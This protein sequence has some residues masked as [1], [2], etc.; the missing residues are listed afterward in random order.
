MRRHSFE[1]LVEMARESAR[2][3]G[4]IPSS[5]RYC[6]E[7]RVRAE[8]LARFGGWHAVALA[9]FGEGYAE[10]RQA[11]KRS[12]TK[13][14]RDA[15]IFARDERAVRAFL[16]HDV[17]VFSCAQND[18][19]PVAGF[20][21]ALKSY[22]RAKDG[23][24]GVIPIRHKN[25]TQRSDPSGEADGLTWHP[26]LV[27]HMI[28]NE[29]RLAPDLVVLGQVRIQA[30][31]PNPLA[32]KGPRT[33]ASSAIFGHPKLMMK[34]IPTSQHE[35][36]KLLY[37]TG[38]I[39]KKNYSG[40]D[41]GDMADF[42]HVSGAIVVERDGDRWWMRSLV[43]DGEAFYDLD[44]R[45][46]AQGFGGYRRVSGLITGDTHVR[47][48]DPVVAQLTYGPGGI[49]EV[50]RPRALVWHDSFDGDTINHHDRNNTILRAIKAAA[51]K[52]RL[53]DELDEWVDFIASASQACPKDCEQIIVRSNHDERLIRWLE[54]SDANVSPENLQI[55][56][57]LKA[58]V[59]KTGRVT[60]RGVEYEDPLKLYAAKRGLKARFLARDEKYLIENVSVTNHGDVGS[61]GAR[62]SAK[63][64]AQIGVRTMTAHDHEGHIVEGN[65]GV[66]TNSYLS[67][68]YNRRGPSSWTHTDGIVHENGRRQLIHIRDGDWRKPG[69]KRTPRRKR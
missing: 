51:G 68:G 9:A 6:Q 26:D 64:F 61:N 14:G 56:Y 67:L 28:E 30:T 58:E 4:G 41:R 42:H 63:G 17:F 44:E 53:R 3:H 33:K 23:V 57:E 34:A 18:T 15:P 20:F 1:S 35:H 60:P 21:S 55:F 59:L 7:N 46:T 49:C 48:V 25:P 27:P 2:H 37:T 66:G 43:W 39:T 12:K 36:A 13:A 45:W 11:D 47:F 69:P 31:A 52:E 19:A 32:S 24:L 29:I 8:T 38:S 22:V 65:W 5:T 62:G 50:L 16:D 40:T 54:A 10:E